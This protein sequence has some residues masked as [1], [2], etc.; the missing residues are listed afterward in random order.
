MT[1]APLTQQQRLVN[2]IARHGWVPMTALIDHLYGDRPDGGPDD[3]ENNWCPPSF[4][5][6]VTRHGYDELD[7]QMSVEEI[8]EKVLADEEEDR[9]FL[10]ASGEA[11]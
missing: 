7:C 2:L 5:A 1:T 4:A 6:G 8:T 11:A 9:R 3:P 10:E